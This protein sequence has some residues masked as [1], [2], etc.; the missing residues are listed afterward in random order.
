MTLVCT[1][2]DDVTI[3]AEILLMRLCHFS[4]KDGY[5]NAFRAFMIESEAKLRIL[6]STVQMKCF[7]LDAMRLFPK[8]T[9]KSPQNFILRIQYVFLATHVK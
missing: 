5:T 4:L 9:R 3:Q 7:T 6:F 1:L 8:I 2:K